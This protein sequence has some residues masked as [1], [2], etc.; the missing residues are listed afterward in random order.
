M[1]P[2]ER[3]FGVIG[4]LPLGFPGDWT[5]TIRKRV[6]DAIRNAESA[7]QQAILKIVDDCQGDGFEAE[8]QIRARIAK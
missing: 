8:R 6:A 5:D 3:A 7:E 2:D 4:Y 1:T